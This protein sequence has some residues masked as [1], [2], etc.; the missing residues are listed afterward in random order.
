MS[1]LSLA[2]LITAAVIIAA[3]AGYALHLTRQVKQ[4]EAAQK[5][6]EA[7]AELQL[8]RY[9]EELVKDIR[10][11]AMSVVQ[12]QCDI[13]EGVLRTQYMIRGLDPAV[14]EMNE[15][16]N[17][18]RHYDAT[19]DMPIL[20]AYKALTPKQ[21]FALDKERLRLEEENKIPVERE[22]RWLATYTFPQVTL[23]Q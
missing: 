22:F 4:M 13:T 15:L 7:Q 18:R 12:Q 3:L 1:P 5:A 6:E 23:L 17:I 14:W 11:I 20:D 9:Q 10:F 19:R 2:L 21:Q 16:E 8:R